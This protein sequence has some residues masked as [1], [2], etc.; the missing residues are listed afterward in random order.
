MK[1]NEVITEGALDYIKGLAKTG[2]LTGAKSASQQA[3]GNNILKKTA[4]A[5]L[6]KW[7]TYSGQTKDTDVQAWA[8]NFFKNPALPVLTDKTPNGIKEY[9]TQAIRDYKIS[10]TAGKPSVAPVQNK[11]PTQQA[12]VLP[13]IP[14]FDIIQH[15]PILVRYKKNDYTLDNNGE[16]IPF[17]SKGKNVQLI[18][19]TYP[20]LEKTLDKVAGYTSVNTPVPPA[21]PVSKN[22]QIPAD[23]TKVAKVTTPNGVVVD[24]WSNGSWS[25]YEN[26]E[27]VLV[28]DIDLPRLEKMLA[29]QQQAPQEEPEPAA[30]TSNRP[31]K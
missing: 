14:G 29:Q 1:I 13:K 25:V 12:Q 3:A 24:K 30:F 9:L 18:K 22:K 8:K 21:A 26:G 6:Q 15:D 23:A 10:Q 16:W 17:L 7:N 28:K 4:D 11:T 5:V 20:A 19:D 2:S 27:L 31:A